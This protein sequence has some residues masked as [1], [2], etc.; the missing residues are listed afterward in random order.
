MNKWKRFAI[1]ASVT[2]ALI[3]FGAAWSRLTENYPRMATYVLVGAL[4]VTVVA[5]LFALVWQTLGER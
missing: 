2:T 4:S 1:S 3:G 5:W